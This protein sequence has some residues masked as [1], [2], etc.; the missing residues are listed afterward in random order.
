MIAYMD[1]SAVVRRVLDQPGADSVTDLWE[2]AATVVSSQVV[3][4]EARAALAAARRSGQLDDQRFE[5][6]ACELE[7]LMDDIQLVGVDDE[8]ADLAGRLAE[9]HALPGADAIHLA[10]AL[11]VDAPRVVVATWDRGLGAA[12]AEC[13]MAVV[14]QV[15]G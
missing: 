6:A 9:D 13:G 4:P 15:A 11:S 1:S 8:Q 14:P 7:R 3:Y 5:A 2:R 10:A 12:S